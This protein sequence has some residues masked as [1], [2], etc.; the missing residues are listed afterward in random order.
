MAR[1][2]LACLTVRKRILVS[3][4]NELLGL[5]ILKNC[6]WLSL[7]VDATNSQGGAGG[8]QDEISHQTMRL[9]QNPPC[10]GFFE[11]STDS[12]AC[13][14]HFSVPEGASFGTP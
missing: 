5:E 12:Q 8:G 11:G 7:Y 13:L 1:I 9:S 3:V 4:R 10:E 14:D 2:S 6:P